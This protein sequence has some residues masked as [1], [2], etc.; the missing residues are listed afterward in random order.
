MA[1][2][3]RAADDRGVHPV[4]DVHTHY[5]PHGWPPLPGAGDRP[6]LRV[7]GPSE[8]TIMLGE[9]RVPAHHRQRVERRR[10]ARGDGPVRRRPAGALPHPGVLLLRPARGRGRR[11]RR[12]L[13]RPR[14]GDRRAGAAPARPVLPGA[15]AGHRRRL[16]RARPGRR[17]RS[18][19]RRDRQP[20]RRPRPRRRGHRHVPPALRRPRRA[21]VR[22]P[23]GHAGHAP[24]P[25][26]DGPVA[27][28]HARRDPPVDTRDGARRRVRPGR[29]ALADLLRARRRLVRVLAR[30]G[31]ERLARPPRRR[32]HLGPAAA[33]V[34]RPVQRRLRRVRRVRAAAARRHARR[35]PR[36][37]GQRL[38]VPARRGGGGHVD[39]HV[40]AAHRRR[41]R[42]QLLAG[43]RRRSWVR[44]CG[45]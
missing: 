13:Q 10:A 32:R 5:V 18:P 20:R 2:R 3:S 31:R 33:R 14:A 8:A 42:P 25:P 7:D 38:P 17:R 36:A 1:D 26:L 23:L 22:A 45:R 6:S 35:R 19:R 12:D 9:T 21:G 37:A 4:T 43:T 29:R 16:P 27:H 40:A 39:P 28:R 34:R 44:G 24:H 30:A 41:T 15:V 11:H